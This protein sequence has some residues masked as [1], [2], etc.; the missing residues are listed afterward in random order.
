MSEAY[1]GGPAEDAAEAQATEAALYHALK[2]AREY[3]RHSLGSRYE[4]PDPYEIV[5]AALALAEGSVRR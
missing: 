4:G 3:M 2:V 5:D 1:L